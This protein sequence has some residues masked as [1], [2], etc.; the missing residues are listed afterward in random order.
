MADTHLF[1][2]GG[3]PPFNDV[4]GK[5]FAHLSSNGLNGTQVAVLFME[6]DGW[7][8]YMP[9]YTDVLE[10]NGIAHFEYLPL[11]PAPSPHFI[12]QLSL[13][14]G[15]IICGGDT[16][17]YREYVVDT[18]IGKI[19]KRMYAEGT[20][21]AGFSAGALISPNICVIPPIDNR[22]NEHLFLPGLGLIDHCVV[23]VHFSK[24]KEETNLKKALTLTNAYIGYGMDDDS[25]IYFKNQVVSETAEQVYFY[26]NGP[27]V[28]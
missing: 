10:Q 2:F 9:R 27:A 22:K 26:R 28:E 15:V 11:T 8:E 16:E 3:G 6:R 21:V 7:K 1:L 14:T 20:P 12:E 18:E 17:R 19:V 23:S 24:W 5:T 4:L 25:G 13:A